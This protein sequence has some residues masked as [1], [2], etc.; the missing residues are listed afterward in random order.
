MLDHNFN[1]GILCP[2]LLCPKKL[3]HTQSICVPRICGLV[4]STEMWLHD[5]SDDTK[6]MKRQQKYVSRILLL[7]Q[8]INFHV[9]WK[10]CY[11]RTFK[12]M[13]TTNIQSQPQSNGPY[14]GVLI[15]DKTIPRKRPNKLSWFRYMIICAF[16]NVLCC[17]IYR[18]IALTTR[19]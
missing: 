6:K 3:L 4:V 17:T 1:L 13:A 12:N 2:I 7:F 9:V 10:Y 5:V 15:T 19:G 18:I 16:V 14:K 8:S 11:Q